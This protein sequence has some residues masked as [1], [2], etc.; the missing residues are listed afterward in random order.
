MAVSE[1]AESISQVTVGLGRNTP[2][3]V[4]TNSASGG[5]LPPA[6][7]ELSSQRGGVKDLVAQ[8]RVRDHSDYSSR[9]TSNFSSGSFSATAGPSGGRL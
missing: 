9:N 3:V 7:E 1:E 6:S 2:A 4:Q 5:G 8:V